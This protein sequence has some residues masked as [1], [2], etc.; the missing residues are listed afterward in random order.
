[1]RG[2]WT[3]VGLLLLVC[4]LVT[5]A[6]RAQ[7]AG[8]T[9]II[10]DTSGSMLGY[11]KGGASRLAAFYQLLYRNA[12]APQLAALT[13]DRRT[14]SA[15][16]ARVGQS[17]HFSA[18]GSYHGETDLVLALQEVERRGGTG[19]LV[20]DGM[21]SGGTYLRVKEELLKMV[22][23][24]W[25]VWLVSVKL[26]FNGKI[27]PEQALDFD[28]LSGHI[29]QCASADDPNSAV[30]H[31]RGSNR[32]YTFAG[33]RPLLLFVLTKDAA[34]G[35]ALT[36]RVEANL[37]ADPQYSAHVAEL[38]PL[39]YRGLTFAP[40]QPVSDYMNLNEGPETLAIRS[41]TVDGQRTKEVWVPVLWR[42][43]EPPVAQ[44]FKE[45]PAFAPPEAVSWVEEEVVTVADE[46]DP[47]GLRSPGR[48]R[49]RF[50]S[51]K[52]WYRSLCFLRFISCD[53]AKSD[54]LKLQVWTEF[55]ESQ[56]QWWNALNVDNSYQCP[57]RVYK[58]AELARD[59]SRAAKE[60][61]KPEEQK[62]T[63]S[64]TLVIGRV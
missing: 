34:A 53:D 26:P 5:P 31:E 46:S 17:A 49:V 45:T 12:E 37:K 51:E 44:P 47:Q 23:G 63:K 20:T 56:D 64:L 57:T 50:V 19:L 27:D 30:T 58:L 33:L 14:G 24:G 7:A 16:V 28:T 55:N 41:D 29:R 62:V 38:A 3:R 48:V 8:E 13:S 18:P 54:A 2:G 10:G 35:R 15:L 61:I 42:A 9:F 40:A 4:A 11:V 25:G 21:P 52:P 32:F 43:G 1:M 60:Q 22:R 39:F 6:A 59:L 36:L